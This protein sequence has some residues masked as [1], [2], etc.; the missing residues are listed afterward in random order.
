M[1]DTKDFSFARHAAKFR[2]HISSSIPGYK[3]GLIPACVSLS[4]RFVQRGTTVLDIGCSTGHTLASIR[5]ANQATRPD[6]NYV[7]IDI[8]PSFREHWN[9]LKASNLRFEEADA[10]V[11]PG[12]DSLSVVMSKFTLQFIPENGKMSVLRRI[13][14]GLL[15]GGALIIAEKTYA[16]TSRVQDAM[17]FPYYDHKLKN[18]FSEKDILDKER[19][20][21][22]QMTLWTEQELRSALRRAGFE[23]IQPIWRSHMFVGYLA[24][25][26]GRGESR[27]ASGL[28]HTYQ[29]RNNF[30]KDLLYAHV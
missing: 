24:L 3:T 11:Y 21:R 22:G 5:R 10:R 28:L 30:E 7:G 12:Y 6:V 29:P 9:R 23:D 26:L 8:E 14:N 19:Q 2:S 20:L 16:E 15:D 13:Y 4:R 27:V 18:G 17:T 25:K 1:N